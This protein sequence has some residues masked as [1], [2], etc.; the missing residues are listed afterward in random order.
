[1]DAESLRRSAPPQ[2]VRV[3]NAVRGEVLRVDHFGNLITN[4]PSG[5]VNPT[6]LVEVGGEVISGLRTHYGTVESGE[7]L[8]LI[9]SGGT[10][11]IS[12]RSESAAARLGVRRGARVNVRAH[13]D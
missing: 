3:G 8:A 9:G 11:E 4:I 5:W 7:L 1:M 12:V 13:R 6:A 10:L 2:P